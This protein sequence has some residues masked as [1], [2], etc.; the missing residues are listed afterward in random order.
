MGSTVQ[1]AFS[2]FGSIALAGAV[3]IPRKTNFFA[4]LNIVPKVSG[5]CSLGMCSKTS[6]DK[7]T[8]KKLSSNVILSALQH[9]QV[10]NPL[11]LKYSIAL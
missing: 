7:I 10:D 6:V 11:C 1:C 8:S 9:L 3:A 2:P 4:L 5:I